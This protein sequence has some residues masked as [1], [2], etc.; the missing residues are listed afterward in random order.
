[1]RVRISIS[2]SKLPVSYGF[3]FL[4]LIKEALQSED[5]EYYSRLFFYDQRRSNKVTKNFCFAIRLPS[6]QLTDNEFIFTDDRNASLILSSPDVELVLKLY[7]GFLKT[8]S[9]SY[10][11][12]ALRITRISLLREKVIGSSSVIFQTMSPICIKDQEGFYLDFDAPN[13]ERELNYIAD[14]IIRNFAGSG[15]KD[16]L[17]FKPLHMTKRVVKLHDKFLNGKTFYVNANFGRFQLTGHP[18]DLNLLY[19][20]G[21]SFRRSEGFGLLELVEEVRL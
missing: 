3:L 2:A 10:Q 4:S 15:L 12:Y 17:N 20:L 14:L 11:N 7:N 18:R 6:F 13:F 9:F 16:T 21:L 1:M 19:Q 8:R 5:P